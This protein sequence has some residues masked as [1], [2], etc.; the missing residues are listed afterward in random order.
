MEDC[1]PGVRRTFWIPVALLLAGVCATAAS[2][3]LAIIAA[4]GVVTI[5][6][7]GTHAIASRSAP[8]S[9]SLNFGILRTHGH[10]L[11]HHGAAIGGIPL[12]KHF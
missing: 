6:F 4:I 8:T 5:G 12:F 1:A 10:P 7:F 2:S 3:L 11:D 9:L